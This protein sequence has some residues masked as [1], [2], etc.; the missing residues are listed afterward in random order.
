[1]VNFAGSEFLIMRFFSQI[2][3]SLFLLL[4]WGS[5]AQTPNIDGQT[6]DPIIIIEEQ[7]YTV[8]FGDLA[9]T[10]DDPY[11]TDFILTV[12]AGG[13]NYTFSSN[14][15]TPAL[16]FNGILTVNVQVTDPSSNASNI[17]AL[18]VQVDAVNDEPTFTKGADPTILEDASA[19]TEANWATAISA[20]PS[21]ESSQ[22]L[23]FGL[24]NTNNALFSVQPAIS[25]TGTLTYTPASN[26][27]GS[28]TVT[29]TLSD[30][31]GT[32]NGGIDNSTQSFT[33]TVNSVNDAPSFTKGL[34]QVV[35]EE[36]S[37]QS[38]SNWATSISGGPSDESSQTLLFDLTNTNNA[39]FSV[40]PAIST[41]GTL[42]YTPAA[43]TSGSATITVML[44]DNGGT[45]NG[46]VNSS[47][48][49]FTITVNSINN[50]P[51]FVKGA[52][53]IILEGAGA[54]SIN[55]WATSISAG[56]ADE[57]SQTLS[58]GLTNTN[59]ALFSVQPAISTTGTLTY[60]PAANTSGSATVTVTLSDN[61]GTANGGIDNST[62][63]FTITINSINNAPSFVKGADPTIL[64]DASAQTEA[65]WATVISAGPSDESSQTLSF[66][67]T[68]TNNA[69]FSVQPAISTTGTLTYTPASNASGS[70]TVNVTL[71]DDGGTANGGIDNS[72][73]SFTITVNSVNDAP[74]FTKGLDQVVS[75]GASAQ[76]ISNWATSISA[77][78]PDES[79]QT[80]LFG[81]TNT[82]NALFSVQ[83]ALSTTGTL[84]YTPAANTSGSAT[85]T[86]MLSDNGGT[87]NG[88]VNNSSQTFTITVNSINNA[89]SFVKG[90]NQIVLEDASAQSINNWATSISAGPADE[91]SQTLSFGLTNTNN[92]LFSVQPAISTTGTLTY[93]PAPNA[94]GSATVT[95]TLSDNGGT[96]NGGIDNSTQTF[97]ITINSVNDAP[98]FVKGANQIILED[99]SAQSISNWATSISAGPA[100]ESSQTLSF[101]LANTNNALFSVQ[102]A[103]STTGTLTYTPAANVSGSATVTVTL[104]D[105]GGTASGGVNSSSQTF[106]ITVTGINDAPTF[107]KGSDQ[108]ILEDAAAQSIAGWATSI[109]PGPGDT[110][111]LLTF[112]LDNNNTSL[113]SVQPSV[114]ATTGALTYTPAANA[115]GVASVNVILSDNGGTANGGNNTSATQTFLIT[116]TPVNDRPVA[117]SDAATTNEDIEVTLNVVSNDTDID[118]TVNASSVDLN[119]AVAGIQST[120]MTIGGAVSVNSSGDVTFT[121]NLNFTG[122]VTLTYTVNDNAGLTSLSATISITVNAVNDTPVANGD[123]TSTNEEVAVTLN[124]LAN[125]TDPDGNGTINATTVDLNPALPGIQSSITTAAGTF[126]VNT[127]GVVSFTPVANFNG[128][129]STTYTVNDNSGAT[130]NVATIS[131][132]VNAVNDLPV[133]AADATSTNEDVAV[134]LNVVSNDVDPDG[135]INPASVDLNTGVAG[136]QSSNTIAA[137]TFAVSSLGVVTYTPTLNFNGTASLNY[138]VSDNDGSSSNIVAITITV[139]AINDPPV[140]NNDA[141]TTNEDTPTTINV[142]ANDTDVDGTIN[143]ATVD[144][145]TSTS[146]IQTTAT[147]S[148]GTLSVNASGVVTFT[149]TIN[150]YGT[151]SA[152]YYV[153]DNSGLTSVSAATVT[154][155]V[156]AVNDTPFA[157]NDITSSAEDEVVTLNVVANDVDIDGSIDPASVDLNTTTGGIQN[158]ITVAA[159]TFTVNS[160]G[161]VT[162]T[163]TLN[164]NGNATINYTVRDNLGGVSGPAIISI[165]VSS[166]NSSPIAGNDAATTN[167]DAAVSFNVIA[168]DSDPDG[169]INAATVD[170]NPTSPGIQ[171]TNTIAS[172]TFVVNPSGVLTF[173]PI[174]NFNGA[175]SITY[176]VN[177]NVGATSNVATIAITVTSINDAPIANNDTGSGNEGV[178]IT[179]NV[180]ANDTDVDGTI[181]IMTVDLNTTAA[182]IQTTANN[183]AG[184]WSVNASGVVTFVSVNNFSGAATLTYRVNDNGGATSGNATITININSIN[185]APV[186]NN[187]AATTN[188]DVAVTLNLITNDTDEESNLSASTVDLNTTTVGI[189][190]SIT[191]AAGVFA[192]NSSGVLTFTPTL[193]FNG[194]A[195]NTYTVNDTGGLTSNVATITITVT[196]AND[197][198]VANNDAATTNED[199]AVIFRITDNDTDIEGPVDL[200]TID[201]NTTTAGIQN[202]N[203]VAAVGTFSVNATGDVTF[204]PVANFF[205]SATLAYT[206]ND[207]SAASSNAG[208]I[209]VVVNAINDAPSF[210]AIA[211]Q[212]IIENSPLQSITI[213]NVSKGP[214]EG[215]QELTWFVSSSNA[216]IVSVQPVTYDGV[217]T[218]AQIKY[219]VSPNTSGT[220]T[221]TVNVVDNGSNLAPNQN[222][223]TTTFTVEV[224]EINNQPTLSAITYGPILED[225]ILQDIPLSGITAGAGE[226]QTLAV[227]ATTDKPELFE[228]FAVVYTPS[229]TLGT[230]KIKPLANAFGTAVITV[231]V[232]DS[233]PNSPVPNVNFITRTFS[234]VIQPVNDLPVFTSSPVTTANIGEVYTYNIKVTDVEGETLTLT[235]P[236]KPTWATIL[237]VAVADTAACHCNYKL[238]GTPPAGSAGSIAVNIQVN[239]PGNVLVSQPYTLVVNTRPTILP[240]SIATGEDIDVNIAASKFTTAFVDA[241]GNVLSEI[242]ILALPKHGTLKLPGGAP[243]TANQKISATTLSNGLVYSPMLNYYGLDTIRWNASDANSYALNPSYINLTISSVNDVPS[244]SPMETDSLLYKSGSEP[245]QLTK[246]FKSHDVDNDSLMSAEVRFLSGTFSPPDDI[247]I[248]TNTK[249]LTGS[250]NAES[251]ILSISGKA[252]INEYDTAIRAIRYKNVKSVSPEEGLRTVSIIV[253]DGKSFSEPKTRLVY[254][255]FIEVALDIPEGFTPA[256]DSSPNNK[257]NI[258]FQNDSPSNNPELKDAVLKVYNKRGLLLFETSGF[259]K[260]WDGKVNG[261]FVPADTYFYT[262]DLKSSS[263]QTFKG[264][265]TVLR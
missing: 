48:Q 234:L 92:A 235:T 67:L 21:D 100:D 233:G 250:F 242:Q 78:P 168:N 225:A 246:I 237:I 188:E 251:G 210:T 198:P 2:L 33:I 136:I 137:G 28:A 166:I 241:D 94:S 110:G 70:A 160:L 229:E 223:F 153:N 22:N 39:L 157:S 63:T 36:A 10:D 84:T 264:T 265:V 177:D 156:N 108:T 127:S 23:S 43:N 15:F 26:A 139:N 88:G 141:V 238:T 191:T 259:E 13:P 6:T 134:T 51:S 124:V 44:S 249:N 16:N 221:I 204:T 232:Q 199:N 111:Q 173:T 101:G 40:Q 252:P 216:S 125:D 59:N 196:P 71:S 96:A 149:P 202:T 62:Q 200:A 231:R 24:T 144:L 79:S 194:A 140:A 154:F 263:Q 179:V 109:S 7:L 76:S 203:T 50:A 180:I 163:P 130:S 98:S 209:S 68:N 222:S 97:T 151:A 162:Y 257:W 83:P 147:I 4:T 61:G 42:T 201:L 41:T 207:N 75:E 95:V 169:S 155:T 12:L 112:T 255:Y 208:T 133:A 261:E 262:I 34:D 260:E 138:S 243:V 192:V 45:A 117:T 30:D 47:S 5:Y 37:A 90:V 14:T 32:A 35:N 18:R 230:L 121:P 181:N 107:V 99:A 66:G 190:N 195:T 240:F 52:D 122:L 129:A 219:T 152:S 145:N 182:G 159:G 17:F 106:T 178:A 224:V 236:A 170:L 91:S 211:N 150:F 165:S 186:A 116:I 248:F 176:T 56:P 247:L 239:D 175:A 184:S 80:L 120:N 104:S 85:I 53:Q 193:N 171:N 126:S 146:G 143:I 93:T 226:A 205:G 82:N 161:V 148:G 27:S 49:T 81:L 131:I 69:L 185:D 142:V 65:N 172:G 55:N 113:F 212:Q 3:L 254:V 214:L 256:D 158:T 174:L 46:G 115:S 220:V 118:G 258:L 19:Q 29:V 60:T 8:A 103:I 89:P 119:T 183:A 164:F 1:L 54:Q 102:P 132:T 244:I 227:T 20:G 77:G 228:T 189:Q 245:L 64:E 167:E 123:A 197:V 31:G 215:A 206:V 213:A 187:D 74:T 11:P 58:F 87:A 9:V 105:N 128:V 135:S 73:Q 38:I 114:N 253:N 217:S 86:V 218:T 25:T 72:T 57:S